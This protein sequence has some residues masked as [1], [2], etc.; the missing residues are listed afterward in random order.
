MEHLMG[1]ARRDNDG[2]RVPCS[3]ELDSGVDT[4]DID[5][6]AGANLQTKPSRLA[7]SVAPLSTPIAM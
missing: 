2:R 5:K 3:E 1:A 7:T 4:T 6:T